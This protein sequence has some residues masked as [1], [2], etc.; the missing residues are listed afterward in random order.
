MAIR[1]RILIADDD[2]VFRDITTEILERKHYECD[3]V[4]D[5]IAALDK[6]K[7]G[8]YDLLLSDINM[9]GNFELELIHN[10]P[11]SARGMSVILMTAYPSSETAIASFE[12]P[13]MNYLKKPFKSAQ[14]IEK[15]DQ[16]VEYSRV[17]RMG[18]EVFNQVDSW[19]NEI[20]ALYSYYRETPRSAHHLPVD[21]FI[22]LALGNI[23]GSLLNIKN[24]VEG[25]SV[26]QSGKEVCR[27]FDC[28]KIQATKDMLGNTIG[29]LEKTRRR[30]KSRELGAIR[31][32][33]EKFLENIQ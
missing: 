21:Q 25:L 13:V 6:L 29:K 22:S 27:L 7:T 28:P 32:D 9:P 15:V 3:G 17:C 24:L 2:D 11:E 33:L 19:S 30:L 4:V 12:L 23:F 18:H 14:L 31:E 16:G 5:G 10:L 20:K 1:G 26:Q 8:N